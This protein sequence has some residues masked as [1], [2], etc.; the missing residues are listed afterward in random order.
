MYKSVTAG[1]HRVHLGLGTK[2]WYNLHKLTSVNHDK[3]LLSNYE[4][5]RVFF[6]HQRM[7][8]LQNKPLIACTCTE[9]QS[10]SEI[11]VTS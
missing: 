3:G 11:V 2:F 8:F 7:A 10:I 6:Y 5:L 1:P 4:L 9:Q